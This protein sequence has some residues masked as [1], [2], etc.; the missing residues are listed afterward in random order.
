MKDNMEQRSDEWFTARLGKVTAS[1]I[2]DVLAKTKNGY[3]ASRINY[4][5]ELICER[6]TGKKADGFVNAA[7]ARGT[8][9]EPV[10]RSIFEVHTGLIVNEVG[11]VA[12]PKIKMAGASPDGLIGDKGLI[13]IKCPNSSTHLDALINK[14]FN[15]KYYYQMQWQMAC[16]ERDWCKFVSYSPDFPEGMDLVVIDVPREQECINEMEAEVTL[17]LKEIDEYINKLKGMQNGKFK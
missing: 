13:E 11:F 1:R 4:M 12:H 3:S 8:E 17:F 10:A 9:L 14:D 15:S 16:T 2:S 7:M 5:T 6:L